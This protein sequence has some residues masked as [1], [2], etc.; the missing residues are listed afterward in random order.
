MAQF[1]LG[2]VLMPTMVLPL[3]V[4]EDRYR[5]LV[6]DLDP[7]EP[8]FGVVLIERGSEV[9][10]ADVRTRT[11]TIARV[12]HL[13]SFDDGRSALVCVGTERFRV[14]RWLP[15]DP[16]PRAE[17][18]VWPD[19]A[20]DHCSASTMAAMLDS[21]DRCRAMLEHHGV[22]CGPPPDFDPDPSVAT[23]QAAAMSPIGD[24]DRL[25]LLNAPGAGSRAEILRAEL[26]AATQ[27]IEFRLGEV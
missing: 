12:V 21:F 3:H 4:F 11:G 18:E 7:E 22:D 26:D 16:Y 17:I 27:L 1:P 25:R 15:D 14:L 19:D 13:E 20:D 9:G 24:L 8:T 23:F 2:S 6:A 5:R 10:G